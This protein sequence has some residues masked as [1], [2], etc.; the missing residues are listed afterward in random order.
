MSGHDRRLGRKSY[1]LGARALVLHEA[2]VKLEDILDRGAL[3]R[4]RERG[5]ARPKRLLQERPADEHIEQGDF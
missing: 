4:R 5:S 2:E 1:V 3:R